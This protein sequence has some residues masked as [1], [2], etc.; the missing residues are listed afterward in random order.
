MVDKKHYSWVFQ[1][2]TLIIMLLF[3]IWNNRRTPIEDQIFFWIIFGV[4]LIVI[5][6]IFVYS[7]FKDQLNKI[8]KHENELKKLKEQLSFREKLDKIYFELGKLNGRRGER[9]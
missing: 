3:F 2:I 7:Y 9:K 8:K 1:I 6:I 4:A 5:F